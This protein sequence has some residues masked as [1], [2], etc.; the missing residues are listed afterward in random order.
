MVTLPATHIS[1]FTAWHLFFQSSFYF[2]TGMLG[3]NIS[4]WIVI[5]IAII[6]AIV[7]FLAFIDDQHDKNI[8]I[9]WSIILGI[10]VMI[11]CVPLLSIPVF[12][13]I[14]PIINTVLNIYTNTLYIAILTTKEMQNGIAQLRLSSIIISFYFF[15]SFYKSFRDE[16]PSFK[17]QFHYTSKTPIIMLKYIIIIS[18]IFLLWILYLNNIHNIWITF[19]SWAIFFIVDDIKIIDDYCNSINGYI[20]K[21]HRKRM[22]IFEIIITLLGMISSY[23][24]KHMWIFGIYLIVIITHWIGYIII[25]YEDVPY[26]EI[27]RIKY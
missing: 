5:I 15:E 26:S 25:E 4:I 13:L 24:L 2:I 10:L 7:A 6:M 19:L 3:F 14:Y 16:K 22:L 1:N 23:Y 27:S 12:I 18:N 21:S 17:T 8:S 9:I 11:A 20:L